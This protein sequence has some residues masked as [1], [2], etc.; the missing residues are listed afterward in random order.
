[1]KNLDH[2]RIE[3]IE[4]NFQG[5]RVLKTFTTLWVEETLKSQTTFVLLPLLSLL[6][7]T[8]R[9]WAWAKNQDFKIL[10]SRLTGA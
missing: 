7:Q 8:I 10:W 6:S 4:E 5:V 1:M 3:G 9:E 2:C